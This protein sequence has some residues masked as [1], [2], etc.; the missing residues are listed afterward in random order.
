[1]EEEKFILW[2]TRNGGWLTDGATYSSDRSAAKQFPHSE[3]MRY[4]RAQYRNGF[5]EF[6]VIPIALSLLAEIA[7]PA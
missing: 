7:R 5:S 6:G 2:H 1:M 3:A 4:A